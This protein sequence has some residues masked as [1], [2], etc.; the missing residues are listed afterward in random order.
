MSVPITGVTI[1]A[2][3]LACAL[4]NDLDSA[5]DRL[6]DGSPVAPTRVTAGEDWP[7]FAIGVDG[8]DWMERAQR[9]ARAV[10]HDIK[11]RAGLSESRWSE[12]PCIVGSSSYSVGAGDGNGWPSLEMPLEFCDQLAR[13][14]GVRGPAMAVTTACTSG[15]GA[16]ALASQL[17]AAGAF[18]EALVLG[19]ELSNRL[20]VAGFAGLELL[21]RTGARPCDRDRDGMVLGEAFGAVLLSAEPGPWHVRALASGMD[22]AS[23]TGPSPDGAA[24]ARTMREAMTKAR[25]DAETVD[26]IKLQASGS[27]MSDAAEA[28]ALRALFSSPHAVS[29][30]GALGH[31]LGAS[32]PAELALLARCLERGR[33]PRTWGFSTPDEALGMIPSNEDADANKVRRVLFNLSGF[34]GNVMTLALERNV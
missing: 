16:I 17:I 8:N 34:G 23:L 20:T 25:W 3:A 26:L 14:F 12:L 28:H 13:W 29:L 5:A 21:S 7:Y 19:V 2:A 1:R 27:P 10:A 4:A 6:L 22:A 31:T 11:A 9:I 24:I 33:V 32:G 18:R 30:K 15:L